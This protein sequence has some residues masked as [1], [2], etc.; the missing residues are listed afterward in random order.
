MRRKAILKNL[1]TGDCIEVEARTDHPLASYRHPVWVD[2]NN[3]AYG[4]VGQPLLG[5]EVIEAN[6]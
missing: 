1:L 3:E 2:E 4:E 5:F 6:N